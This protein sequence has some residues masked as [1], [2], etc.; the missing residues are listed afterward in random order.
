MIP[1]AI[2]SGID[3]FSDAVLRD[4]YPSFKTLRD[5]GP[6]AWL[7]QHGVWYIGR[8]REASRALRDW[9]TF[10]SGSGC[11]LNDTINQLWSEALICEDPPI[12]TEKRKLFDARLSPAALQPV[13]DIIDA[14]ADAM[15]DG[16]LAKGDIDIVRDIAQDLPIHV[17][18]DLIGWPQDVRPQLLELGSHSLN[19]L[20]PDNARTRSTFPKLEKIA[21]LCS[22]VYEENSLTPGGFGHTVAEAARA[23]HL[24]KEAVTGLLA[25]YVVA[26][27]DTT[28]SG[29]ASGCWLFAR[30]PQEWDKL[31]ANPELV[32]QAFTEVIRL[33][34]PIQ[35]FARLTTRDVDMGD[36]VTIPAGSR[37]IV[38]YAAAN[39][40]ERQFDDPD[41]FCITRP[42]KPTL[43]FSA[44]PHTCAGQ[45]LARLEANAVFS[46]MARRISRIE[47]TG[48]P[49]RELDNITRGFTSMPA[50]VTA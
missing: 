21:Q 46:A 9:E 30:H 3:I 17:V 26:A 47:L 36:G 33:E 15:V 5:L 43:S 44:G 12:H 10:S 38:S 8:Y 41:T 49:V 48:E 19:S 32:K 1:A 13:Q 50:R 24:P 28:I 2:R 35:H 25:G 11:G 34:T 45:G 18:M 22:R 42:P 40:D 39:R 29:I 37:V 27:F 31:R 14:R 16:L 23:G 6:A 4:P 20:G 7:D